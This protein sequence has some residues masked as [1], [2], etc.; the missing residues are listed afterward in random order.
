MAALAVQLWRR[1]AGKRFDR[2]MLAGIVVVT[3]FYAISLGMLA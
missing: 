2:S 1:R 3:L